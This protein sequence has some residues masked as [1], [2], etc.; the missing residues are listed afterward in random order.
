MIDIT[1]ILSIISIIISVLLGSHIAFRSNCFGYATISSD[2]NTLDIKVGN[3]E[4]E[5]TAHKIEI[6]VLD[7]SGNKTILTDLSV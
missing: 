5:I 6:D 4:T 7:A 2:G 3:I 1:G